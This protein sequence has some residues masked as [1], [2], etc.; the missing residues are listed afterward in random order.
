MQKDAE[1]K[2]AAEIMKVMGNKTAIKIVCVLLTSQKGRAEICRIIS[3]GTVTVCQQVARLHAAGIIDLV[4]INGRSRPVCKI[5]DDVYDL[6]AIII[7]QA[8]KAAHQKWRNI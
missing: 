5:R 3:E 2:R 8:L 1:I 4:K 6:A 7:E